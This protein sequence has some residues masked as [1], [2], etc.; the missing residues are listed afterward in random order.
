[1]LVFIY[2]QSYLGIFLGESMTKETKK[3]KKQN[4]KQT[5]KLEIKAKSKNQKQKS[6][7]VPIIISLILGFVLCAFGVI[8]ASSSG[9]EKA[10]D[11][12]F[13]EDCICKKI[14]LKKSFQ[15]YLYC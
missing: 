13:A 10:L 3:I 15:Q 14:R 1:M 12:Y 8:I 5:N 4:R 6:I 7:K 11:G 2:S 9:T